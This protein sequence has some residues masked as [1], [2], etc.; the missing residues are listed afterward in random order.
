[1][2]FLGSQAFLNYCFD[3]GGFKLFLLLLLLLFLIHSSILCRLCLPLL[4]GL[5]KQTHKSGSYGQ[6]TNAYICFVYDDKIWS[7]KYMY[8]FCLIS[9]GNMIYINRITIILY[10]SYLT[11]RLLLSVTLIPMFKYSWTIDIHLLQHYISPND[12]LYDKWKKNRNSNT[13]SCQ[14]LLGLFARQIK[15]FWTDTHSWNH[16]ILF[17]SGLTYYFRLIS[18][19]RW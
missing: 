13:Q 19:T 1:M 9:L 3:G 18:N 2:L 11:W 15:K 14:T 10:W 12:T 5:C 6:V 4:C 16:N 8:P 17:S 7:F